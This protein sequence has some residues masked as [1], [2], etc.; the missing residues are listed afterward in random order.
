MFKGVKKLESSEK[1][2]VRE[3]VSTDSLYIKI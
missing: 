2:L 1:M 3:Q